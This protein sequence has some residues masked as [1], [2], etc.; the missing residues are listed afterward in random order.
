MAMEELA[1]QMLRLGVP[2]GD[3]YQMAQWL[4]HAKETVDPE[5]SWFR[6]AMIQAAY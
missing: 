3:R 2:T 6:L 5:T 4:I 1:D